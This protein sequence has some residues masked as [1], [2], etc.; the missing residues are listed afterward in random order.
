MSGAAPP[1]CCASLPAAL[2][3]LLLLSL[4]ISNTLRTFRAS[5][6][7]NRYF[8]N[9]FW[10]KLYD[11]QSLKAIFNGIYRS[12]MHTQTALDNPSKA[13]L[14]NPDA[15][16][17]KLLRKMFSLFDDLLELVHKSLREISY[18]KFVG[19]T[20]GRDLRKRLEHADWARQE[21]SDKGLHI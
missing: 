19:S 1:P 18:P 7:D 2:S 3:S 16:N 8:S 21:F 6:F 5:F 4:S 12:L 13:A 11:V 10:C 9:E 15:H 17:N 20:I 14:L